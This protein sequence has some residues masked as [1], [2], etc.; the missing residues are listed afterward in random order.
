MEQ[1][2]IEQYVRCLLEG[3]A[4]HEDGEE[5]VVWQTLHDLL[6]AVSRYELMSASEKDM[7]TKLSK[8]L[9]YHFDTKFSLKER[10][11]KTKKE[12]FPPNP[13]LKEK[14]KKEKEQNAYISVCD[15]KEAFR[16]ECLSYVNQYDTQLLTNFY[17]YYSIVNP[18][19]GKMHFEEETYW[20]TKQKLDLWVANPISAEITAAS[21][22]AKKSRSKQQKEQADTKAQQEQAAEREAANARREQ[23]QEAAKAGAVTADEQIAR[24]PDGILAR[25]RREREA[26]ENAKKTTD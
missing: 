5:R 18:K 3:W 23:E 16:K 10:K 12:N 17:N 24:N 2:K 8:K 19:T 4:L 1:A 6:M 14:Q 15:A 21:E 20:D 26:K 25:L 13:L 22:R 7:T 9:Q 11:R